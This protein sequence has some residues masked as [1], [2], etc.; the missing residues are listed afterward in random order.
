MKNTI[1]YLLILTIAE[2]CSAALTETTLTC[3]VETELRTGTVA[4]KKKT[5][6]ITLEITQNNELFVIGGTGD[7]ASVFA[8]NDSHSSGKININDKSSAA[9]FEVDFSSE[10]FGEKNQKLQIDDFKFRLDRVTGVLYFS[11]TYKA[12]SPR[13]NAITTGTCQ[14]ATK[15]F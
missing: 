1:F 11:R 13:A 5:E 8:T 3:R 10:S 15:K 7:I 2:H 12:M 4:F 6:I 14:K 9:K